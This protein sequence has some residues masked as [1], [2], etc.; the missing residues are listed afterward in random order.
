MLMRIVGEDAGLVDFFS[1]TSDRLRTW[2]D[3][4]IELEELGTFFARVPY[5]NTEWTR[6]TNQ[7]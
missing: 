3:A 7:T 1:M 4:E 6:I 5:K 2:R